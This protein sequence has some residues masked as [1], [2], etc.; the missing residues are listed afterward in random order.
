M[1]LVGIGNF[2][3]EKYLQAYEAFLLV[4]E[5]FKSTGSKNVKSDEE[6]EDEEEISNSTAEGKNQKLNT[7]IQEENLDLRE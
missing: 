2:Y 5:F 1:C 7:E 3:I 4:F 6:D